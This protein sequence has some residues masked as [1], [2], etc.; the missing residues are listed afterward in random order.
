[1]NLVKSMLY[2]GFPSSRKLR[3]LTYLPSL[4]EWRSKR[5]GRY[6]VLG[7]REALYRHINESH[8]NGA[9][10]DYLEFGVYRG[11]SVRNWTE[12]NRNPQ[13]RFVGFDTFTG[14]PEA[15]HKFSRTVEVKAFDAGGMPPEI[16]DP[17]VTFVKGLFQ[18]TLAEFLRSYTSTRP[19]V[20]HN[21]SD[22]YSA[23]LFVL[24]AMNRVAGAGTII[25]FDE[26]TSLLHE[27]RA[28]EDYCAACMRDYDVIAATDDD[29]QIAIR[30]K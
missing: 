27:F 12:L 30:L 8:L 21:D 5:A 14:L 23:T 9:A 24:T 11:D 13:S 1:M 29:I 20:V 22:L 7:D 25:I 28:L 10:I 4:R 2:H 18:D 19:L 6:P 26:F 17:R 3:Y 15:W 16:A